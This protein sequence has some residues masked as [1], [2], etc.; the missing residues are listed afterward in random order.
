MSMT[1]VSAMKS[2]RVHMNGSGAEKT[3]FIYCEQPRELPY[4]GMRL[5]LPIFQ[6]ASSTI[7]QLERP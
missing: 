1:F 6:G 3:N 2:H 5:K 4:R 7:Y